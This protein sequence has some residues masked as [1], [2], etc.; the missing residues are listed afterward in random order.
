MSRF[1]MEV[2][3][4]GD[5]AVSLYRNLHPVFRLYEWTAECSCGWGRNASDS[6]DLAQQLGRK[7]LREVAS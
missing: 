5:H 2:F 1:P 6:M 7:H 4:E 3:S